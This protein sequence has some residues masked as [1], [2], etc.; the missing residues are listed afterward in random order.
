MSDFKYHYNLCECGNPKKDTSKRCAKCSTASKG[1]VCPGCGGIKSKKAKLCRSCCFPGRKVEDLHRRPWYGVAPNFSQIP[2]DY[3]IAFAGFLMGEGCISIGHNP[4]WSPRVDIG[5]HK[6]DD[7]TVLLAQENFGGSIYYHSNRP[8]VTWRLQGLLPVKTLLE[9][10]RPSSALLSAIKI[11]DLDIAL[12]YINWRLSRKHHL[13]KED[14]VTRE[15]FVIRMK[16]CK[17]RSKL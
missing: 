5:V 4:H 13:T 12:E 15:T 1:D 2:R 10:I 11:D 16:S 14:K 9:L 7:G 6:D 8:L 3:L 17:T